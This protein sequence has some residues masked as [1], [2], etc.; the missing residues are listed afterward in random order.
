[1]Q[2]YAGVIAQYDGKIA[3]V[4]D[5]YEAWD[6]AY[7]NLPSGGVEAGESPT[8]GA[9][10]ELREET[11]LHTTDDALRLVWTTR[12]SRTGETLSRSWNYVATV[13]DAT[14]QIDDPDGTITDAA[15]FSPQD[16]VR[17]LHQMPYPPI[18][19]PALAYLQT[20]ALAAWT[21]TLSDTDDWTWQSD[22]LG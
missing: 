5:R 20:A 16:A 1:V 12:V 19:I 13:T 14:F 11:G 3:L 22:P 15:W 7:W 8:A 17:L 9:I 10:R 2:G 6:S 21:F 18:A 4:H